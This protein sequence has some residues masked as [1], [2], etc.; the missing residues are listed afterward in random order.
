MKIELSASELRA[1]LIEYFKLPG[2]AEPDPASGK[3]GA[4]YWRTAV[5]NLHGFSPSI[6]V[7]ESTEELED[8]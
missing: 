3:L 4:A 5:I 7:T 6:E 1:A 2:R 8:D